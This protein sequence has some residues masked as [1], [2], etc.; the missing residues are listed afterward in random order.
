MSDTVFIVAHAGGVAVTDTNDH[1]THHS[2]G[3]AQRWLCQYSTATVAV[4]SAVTPVHQPRQED[5][6]GATVHQR[7]SGGSFQRG[8]R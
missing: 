8:R 1:P 6:P 3:A 5:I 4:V 7:E 2:A